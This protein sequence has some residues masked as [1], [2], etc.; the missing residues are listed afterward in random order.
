MCEKDPL[1]ILRSQSSPL[2]V[3][4]T[5]QKIISYENFETKLTTEEQEK[6]K[7]LLPECDRDN[8]NALF[9]QNDE[10]NECM[11]DYCILLESGHFDVDFGH[12]LDLLRDEEFSNQDD[13]KVMSNY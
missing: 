7:L 10:F 11:G 13:W 9:K 5:L 4:A 8:M 6:L 1:L 3:L 2:T 12:Q